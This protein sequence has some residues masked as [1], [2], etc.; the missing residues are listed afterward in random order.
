M[1]SAQKIIQVE[2]PK[3]VIS[4]KLGQPSLSNL[5]IDTLREASDIFFSQKTPKPLQYGLMQGNEEFRCNLAKFLTKRYE[6][7]NVNSSELLITNGASNALDMICTLYTKAGDTVFVEDPTYFIIS[8]IFSDHK[9]N[10]ISIPTDKNGMRLDVLEEKLK[11]ISPVF[12]YTIPTFQNPSSTTTSEK[13][14]KNFIEICSSY[15]CFIVAD[16]VYHLL[17]YFDKIPKPLI[18]YDRNGKVISINSFSKIFAPG[19][20]LGWLHTNNTDAMDRIT[21]SGLL[22]S[23]GG[24]NPFTSAIMSELIKNDLLDKHLDYLLCTYRKRMTVLTDSL[25][26]Y[27]NN[28]VDFEEAKGGYYTWVKIKK[29]I[30]LSELEDTCR[31]FKVL[32]LPGTYCSVKGNFND[33]MRLCIS[34]HNPSEIE[35]GVKRIAQA[36]DV[37]T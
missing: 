24:L 34:Y 23:G 18:D 27:L 1:N 4:L 17:K 19:I 8:K 35:E 13:H 10:I 21:N 32:F 6:K 14:R 22:F 20:R 12:I 16:E 36:F 31:K 5:P 30:S 15:S 11:K 29:G 28:Y 25:R 33:Y 37:I 2:I 7:S 3:D 9:L 26:K